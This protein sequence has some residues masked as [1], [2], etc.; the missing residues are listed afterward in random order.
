MSDLEIEAKLEAPTADAL[1]GL[2][3]QLGAVGMSC[4]ESELCIALDHYL[5]TEDLLFR[6]A[7][8]A[9]RLRDL[10]TRKL[11]TLK[12]L[13]PST[14]GLAVREELEEQVEWDGAWSFPTDTLGG[15]VAEITGD[16]PLTRLFGLRQDRTQLHA[17]NE[18]GLWV[19][20]SLDKVRWES[21]DS[22]AVAFVAELEI[23]QGD[24]DAL[25][26]LLR[27]LAT[28]TGWPPADWSKYEYG[29]SVA[30]LS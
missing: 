3:R 12:A 6:A 20:V 5:D 13:R 7:G 9:L 27:R 30:G 10:G 23:R 11:L 17:F 29:L 16:A 25:A 2:P 15:K 26:D 28:E 19:E 4:G 24:A 14:D 18:D 21:G 22:A 8:W 1:L